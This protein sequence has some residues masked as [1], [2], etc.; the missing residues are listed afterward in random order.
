MVRRPRKASLGKSH[1]VQTGRTGKKKKCLSECELR[2]EVQDNPPPFSG[3]S[4]PFSTRSQ[5]RSSSRPTGTPAAAR[6][7]TR[8]PAHSSQKRVGVSEAVAGSMTSR[9]RIAVSIR[10][11]SVFRVFPIGLSTPLFFGYFLVFR[12]LPPPPISHTLAGPAFSYVAPPCCHGRGLALSP[13]PGLPIP[14][15]H[16]LLWLG[17]KLGPSASGRHSSG[18]GAPGLGVL[19]DPPAQSF[20]E[21][22]CELA[23]FRE[24]SLGVGPFGGRGAGRRGA[25]E[26]F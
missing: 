19:A 14:R 8:A 1:S 17:R 21:D 4:Q 13:E 24:G 10:V 15:G 18:P 5:L 9:S 26:T 6:L 7:H 23:G 16:Y 22:T 3:K 20:P 2:D 25:P 11:T 12:L